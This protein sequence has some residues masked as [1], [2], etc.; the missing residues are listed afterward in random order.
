MMYPLAIGDYDVV[1]YLLYSLVVYFISLVSVYCGGG[2]E[3]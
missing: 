1:E 2:E 3:I